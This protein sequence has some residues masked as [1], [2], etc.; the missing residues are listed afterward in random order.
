MGRAMKSMSFSILSRMKSRI[1]PSFWRGSLESMKGSY[2]SHVTSV[3]PIQNGERETW[4][5]SSFSLPCHVKEAALTGSI[6]N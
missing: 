3:F 5:V 2:S 4:R 6:S 1:W